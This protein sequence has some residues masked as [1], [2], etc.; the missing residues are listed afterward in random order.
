MVFFHAHKG[1]IFVGLGVAVAGLS[2]H[3]ERVLIFFPAFQ[4][5]GQAFPFFL[6][7][8]FSLPTA[9]HKTELLRGIFLSAAQFC[10]SGTAGGFL[11]L[12]F[13]F[14]QLLLYAFPPH[15]TIPPGSTLDLCPVDEYRFVVCFAH[16]FQLIHKLVEQV[17]YDLPAAPGAESRQRCVIR[18]FAVL[19]QPHEVY[20]V[21]TGFLQ[22]PAR[23][24]PAKIP[25][26]QY[27]E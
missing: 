5:S 13:Y 21:P 4:Q 25:M 1:R 24:D 11:H 27:L 12:L 17:L 2:Q 9:M 23:I 18:R 15:K 19:Q 16:L 26:H 8:A 7:R 20:P 14:S 3:G 22:L 10:C 6:F